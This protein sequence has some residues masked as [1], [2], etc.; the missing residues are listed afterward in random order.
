[1]KKLYN[2]IN[3]FL[4]YIKA[5]CPILSALYMALWF[6]GFSPLVIPQKFIDVVEIFAQMIRNIVHIEIPHK[7]TPVD[8][9]YIICGLVFM[10]FFFVITFF[11]KVV[12]ELIA[13]DDRV[14]HKGKVVE[15]DIVNKSLE[16]DY[17]AE[18]KRFCVFVILFD[19][20]L[21]FL[22]ENLADTTIDL[23]EFKTT[24][25][26]EISTVIR[27]KYKNVKFMMSDKLFLAQNSFDIFDTFIS[28]LLSLLEEFVKKCAN[29]NVN[30]E[31]STSIDALKSDKNIFSYID[32][33]EKIYSFNYK[34]RVI[35]TSAF[36]TRYEIL[37][38]QRYR[39]NSIGVSRFFSGQ[40]RHQDFELY[41]LKHIKK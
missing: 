30:V 25:Y 33:L 39:F 38:R 37:N 28:D 4:S 2:G 35:I 7:D 32:I 24:F 5:L 3:I 29:E 27:A 10:A 13:H 6:I 26:S 34:N 22:N 16:L 21:K 11:I 31:F 9:T 17:E 14:K 36:K 15:Q 19:V 18:I 23:E 12:K 8:M 40:G 20:N 1:M 41:E